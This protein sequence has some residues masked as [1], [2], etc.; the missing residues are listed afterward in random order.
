MKKINKNFNKI[1]GKMITLLIII[2]VCLTSIGLNY[3]I[4][5]F[6]GELGQELTINDGVKNGNYI[7]FYD[8]E[9]L[10]GKVQFK[11]GEE[12][13]VPNDNKIIL[14]TFEENYQIGIYIT[15]EDG[16]EATG[17]SVNEVSYLTP[18]P[19]S[20]PYILISSGS[21]VMASFNFQS[22]NNNPEPNGEDGPLPSM[23]NYPILAYFE[24]VL[25]PV[26]SDIES[27]I[28]LM[29]TNWTSGN[30]SFK[31]KICE[32]DG[33]IAPDDGSTV[34]D[35]GTQVLSNLN[36]QGISNIEQINRTV[37]G[38]EENEYIIIDEAFQNYG[39]VGIH[40]TNDILNITTDII[41]KDLINVIAMAPLRMSYS[42]GSST[43]DEAIVTNV[44]NGN[45]SI[46]FGNNEVILFA[47]GPQVVG[48][49]NLTGSEYF[50]NNE[51]NSVT[52]SLPALSEETITPVNIEIELSGGIKVTRKI[53]IIRTAIELSFEGEGKT[54]NAG[55]IMHKAYLYNNQAHDD[56]IFNAYLQVILYKDDVVVG[57]KQIQIDDE[58]FINNLGENESGSIES[59][60][61]EP[62]LL[63]SG[64]IEGVNRASVFLTNGPIDYNSNMLPSIEFGLGAGVEIE[65]EI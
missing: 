56:E 19:G 58:E 36:I 6:A 14:P 8:G 38:G 51:D 50:L 32:K 27:N 41:S 49:T 31:A 24:G 37:S 22:T 5:V 53:N 26:E 44:T 52:I 12:V 7:E 55:Y 61:P 1:K 47:T 54:L 34:C 43:I 16:Y 23:I 35:E 57:Y 25:T 11:I 21:D 48:I 28:I 42:Y 65:W 60:G 62:I 18:G 20:I 30:V 15:N 9:T 46:F 40:L 63:F 59:F 3:I 29:P 2:S 4:P 45:V 64:E 10:K 17:Y 13:L 33:K 39:K